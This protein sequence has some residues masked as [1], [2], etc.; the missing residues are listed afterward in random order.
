MA[1]LLV[2]A[3]LLRGST[4][5]LCSR[6]AAQMREKDSLSQE[7]MAT[8]KALAALKADLEAKD[9]EVE[10]IKTQMVSQGGYCAQQA[11][12]IAAGNLEAAKAHGSEVIEEARRKA[13][14]L[15]KQTGEEIEKMLTQIKAL[16]EQA[17]EAAEVAKAQAKQVASQAAEVAQEQAKQAADAADVARQ[18]AQQMANQVAQGS[19]LEEARAAAGDAA[20][21]MQSLVA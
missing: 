3:V 12:R 18:Q 19:T 10:D 4:D 20:K 6:L 17:A 15:E 1:Q 7:L 21:K 9:Q 16:M 11:E 8:E 13:A 14:L 5:V 2:K